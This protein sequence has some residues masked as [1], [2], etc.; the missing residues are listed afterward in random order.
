MYLNVNIITKQEYILC[1][2]EVTQSPV[3]SHGGDCKLTVFWDVTQCNEKFTDVS[4]KLSASIFRAEERV[5]PPSNSESK[6]R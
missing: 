4:E 2:C 5:N 1:C 3:H 6:S